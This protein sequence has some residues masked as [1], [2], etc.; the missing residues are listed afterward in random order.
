MNRG[1]VGGSNGSNQIRLDMGAGSNHNVEMIL[2]L[3]HDTNI[4]K[5]WNIFGTSWRNTLGADDV[6]TGM[7]M[8]G[9]YGETKKLTGLRLYFSSIGG[10]STGKCYY[11]LL[12]LA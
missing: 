7:R 5:L 12:G 9:G 3:P 1:R 6:A 2:N 4:D 11:R 10:S 8:V